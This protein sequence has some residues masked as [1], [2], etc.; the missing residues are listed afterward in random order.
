MILRPPISTLTDTLFPY[1]TLFR[2]GRQTRMAALERCRIGMLVGDILGQL[3]MDGAG[4]F[5]FGEAKGFAHAARDIV[6]R[7]HLVRIFGDRPHH[8][9][10]V[11]DLE[12]SLL[13]RKSTRLNSSH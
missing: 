9:D 12:T 2:S 4:L 1:T 3:D 5:L 13:D 8:R 6:R 11:E 10:D 7:R